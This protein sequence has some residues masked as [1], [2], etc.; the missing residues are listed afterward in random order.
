MF[1]VYSHDDEIAG[2][3]GGILRTS[4]RDDVDT[5]VAR[6]RDV[7]WHVQNGRPLNVLRELGSLELRY[8][9]TFRPIADAVRPDSARTVDRSSGSRSKLVGSNSPRL[10]SF[11]EGGRA[12]ELAAPGSVI[13][14]PLSVTCA[15]AL[16]SSAAG[17]PRGAD[18]Y[19]VGCHP[20][21]CSHLRMA[22]R[23]KHT[24]WSA[25]LYEREAQQR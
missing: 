22:F 12:I 5:Y 3:A 25:S 13:P 16:A 23:D 7:A 21:R 1:N 10:P 15:A 17:G 11:L 6:V 14:L 20:K 18:G 4:S 8:D 2:L 9:S 24:N 19:P